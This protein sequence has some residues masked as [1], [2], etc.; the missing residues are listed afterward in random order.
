[1][2]IGR[3]LSRSRLVILLAHCEG[4]SYLAIMGK[5]EASDLLWEFNPNLLI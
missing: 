1:M 4:T 5:A 3:A 2:V